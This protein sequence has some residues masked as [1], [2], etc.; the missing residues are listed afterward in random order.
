MFETYDGIKVNMLPSEAL[1]Y[2][3]DLAR[4]ALLEDENSFELMKHAGEAAL[5]DIEQLLD[6]ARPEI[7]M[8]TV[9]N[10][11]RRRQEHTQ[12]ISIAQ[13]FETVMG[14]A[15]T[16]RLTRDDFEDDPDLIAEHRRQIGA[17]ELAEGF[18]NTYANELMKILED[19][20]AHDYEAARPTFSPSM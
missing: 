7:D 12:T 15:N 20:R 19:A 16:V 13:K 1:E 9:N 5:Q 17:F 11:S 14:L 4:G 8:L 10:I 18:V 2:V 3:A 6:D